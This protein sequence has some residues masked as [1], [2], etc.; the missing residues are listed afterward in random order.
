MGH[1]ESFLLEKSN[2]IFYNNNKM[3]YEQKW[4]FLGVTM[5]IRQ[6]DKAVEILNAWPAVLQAV[7]DDTNAFLAAGI[8]SYEF[9]CAADFA[10]F[11]SMMLNRSYPKLAFERQYS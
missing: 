3:K 11:Q 6:A 9:A 4:K 7:V 1:R 5:G 8:C 2:G 10:Q